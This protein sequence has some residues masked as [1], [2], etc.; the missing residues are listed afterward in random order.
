MTD[1]MDRQH[2]EIVFHSPATTLSQFASYYISENT[3]EMKPLKQI[4]V[5]LNSETIKGLRNQE[6]NKENDT[7]ARQIFFKCPKYQ[8]E[9]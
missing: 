7:K 5:A 1:W 6:A 8:S 3:L 9:P 2:K 4:W